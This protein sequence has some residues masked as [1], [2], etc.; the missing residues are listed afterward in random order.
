MDKVPASDRTLFA[1][2]FESWAHHKQTLMEGFTF[3][4]IRRGYKIANVVAFD[5]DG[6]EVTLPTLLLEEK[7][8]QKLGRTVYIYESIGLSPTP[9]WM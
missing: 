2:L 9:P 8:S 6:V 7:I 5:V 1:Y 3:S 4:C